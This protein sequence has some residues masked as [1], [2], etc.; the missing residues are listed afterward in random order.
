MSITN[1]KQIKL[2]KIASLLKPEFRQCRTEWHYNC[3]DD[4]TKKLF[5][6]VDTTNVSENVYH[7]PA[8]Q[9]IAKHENGLVLDFG[10]G[11][12]SSYLSN[13]VNLEIVAYESTDV[14]AVGEQLPFRDEVFDAVHSNAV[15]EH[16]KDPFACAKEIMRVL[17]PG[18]DLM[19]CVPLLQPYHGYP[20]HYYN[21]THQG[22]CNLFPGINVLGV[23]VYEELRPITSL[24]WI[25]GSWAAGLPEPARIQFLNMRLGEILQ[26]PYNSIKT[27]PYVV[28]LPPDK[29][30]ELAC[31]NTLFGRKPDTPI[32]GAKLTCSKAMYGAGST[33]TDVTDV[34]RGL[35]TENRVFVSCTTDLQSIFGDPLPGVPKQLKVTWHTST[36]SGE[37]VISEFWGRL[38]T[39]LWL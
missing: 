25:I 26:K 23:E 21:M 38:T 30:Q 29:N 9:L 24:H 31:C 8:L 10:A 4:E 1:L 6:I 27:E 20:R 17:K 39:P 14:I 7:V 36:N 37:T 16:V 22:L 28:Q 3:L 13:V 5:S 2:D 12:R 15:L 19:C 18:G 33:W 32:S 35:I 34:I 11:K